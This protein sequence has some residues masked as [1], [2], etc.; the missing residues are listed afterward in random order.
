MSLIFY[1][2]SQVRKDV[3]YKNLKYGKVKSCGCLFKELSKEKLH[4]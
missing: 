3:L 1:F 2:S 4:G